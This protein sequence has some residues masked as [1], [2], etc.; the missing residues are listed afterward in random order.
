MISFMSENPTAQNVTP[1]GHIYE[2]KALEAAS[3]VL[4]FA[5]ERPREIPKAVKS[6]NGMQKVP[7]S[8]GPGTLPLRPFSSLVPVQRSVAV[9]SSCD[10]AL[11][12]CIDMYSKSTMHCL[13]LP[14]RPARLHAKVHDSLTV[15]C[16]VLC[17]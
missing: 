14:R 5:G 4:Q 9:Q 1:S 11:R 2:Q 13:Q 15:A 10:V 17:L 16:N 8:M 3:I 12:A 7:L 6:Y